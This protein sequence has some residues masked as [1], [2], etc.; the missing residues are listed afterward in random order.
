MWY[1]AKELLFFLI[2]TIISSGLF[3]FSDTGFAQTPSGSQADIAKEGSETVQ[4][5]SIKPLPEIPADEFDQGAPRNS[6]LGFFKSAGD[7]DYE[8]AAEYLDF[9]YLPK[10]MKG[11]PGSELA[12]QLKIVLDRTVWIDF[13]VLSSHPK[14]HLD[15]GLPAY[16]GYFRQN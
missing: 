5:K 3:S 8:R 15:D 11:I 1:I 13:S 10:E 12:G 6:L 16:R 7:S 4:K 2:V 9:R 14:G